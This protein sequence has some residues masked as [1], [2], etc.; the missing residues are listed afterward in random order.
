MGGNEADI[1][2]TILILITVQELAITRHKIVT[3][4]TTLTVEATTEVDTIT[5]VGK[6]TTQLPA[7]QTLTEKTIIADHLT[8]VTIHQIRLRSTLITEV[9]SPHNS[10]LSSL[11]HGL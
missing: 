6:V 2:A 9:S 1:K 7:Q 5:T 8:T 10:K 11:T 4:V 3:A